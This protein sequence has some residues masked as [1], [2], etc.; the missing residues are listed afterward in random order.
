MTGEP[1]D[2]L[3]AHIFLGNIRNALAPIFNRSVVTVCVEWHGWRTL[4]HIAVA[5]AIRPWDLARSA[6]NKRLWRATFDVRPAPAW[7]QEYRCLHFSPSIRTPGLAARDVIWLAKRNLAR[8]LWSAQAWEIAPRS[9]PLGLPCHSP[10]GSRRAGARPRGR[11]NG[12]SWNPIEHAKARGANISRRNQFGVE[13]S[14][15]ASDIV[16]T[17]SVEG[18]AAAIARIASPTAGIFC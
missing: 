7:V 15:D 10:A 14:G 8:G 2:L 17:R 13:M 1:E 4:G 18:P 16:I 12:S 3:I 5:R 9:C 11:S 6:G